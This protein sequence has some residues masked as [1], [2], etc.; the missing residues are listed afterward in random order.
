M[1][2]TL[3]ASAL[4]LAVT[5]MP[6]SANLLTNGSFEAGTGGSPFTTKGVG[7]PDITGW[8]IDGGTVD[9][10]DGYWAA[11]DGVRSIDIAGDAIGSISQAFAT[12]VGSTY[13]VSFDLSANPDGPAISRNLLVAINGGAPSLFSHA[14]TSGYDLASMDWMTH[15]FNF[16]ATGAS[17]ILSF[18]TDASASTFYGPALDNVSVLAA[19]P[20][21]ATW[22]MMLA[23]F[24]LVGGVMRRRSAGVAATV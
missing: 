16:T 2:R 5:A 1:T 17:T 10:I 18:T 4:L 9:Y 6:A 12:I 15:S 24:G 7:S 13:T 22:M 3:I 23:G 11:S 20:E 21:S 14:D 19:V 8:S